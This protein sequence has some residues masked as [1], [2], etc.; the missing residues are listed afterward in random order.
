MSNTPKPDAPHLKRLKERW[1]APLI[2]AGYTV[3]PNAIL[4][5][6][7]ALGL[8]SVDLNILL[9]IASHWWSRDKLPFPSKERIA[10]AIGVKNKST[11]RKRLAAL[12]KGQL[13]RR[14]SRPGR[15]GGNDTNA[16]DLSP[17]IKAATPYALEII[18]EIKEKT[19]SKVAK[20]AKKGKPQ[21]KVVG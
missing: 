9:Q 21:L 13:I 15:H 16:Y 3:I 14:V 20:L 18:Q 6:Q 11:V 8:D 5:R 19:E 17:L 4:L 7:R 12:E 2:D 1:T 10:K